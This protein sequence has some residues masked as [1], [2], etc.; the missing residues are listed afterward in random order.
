VYLFDTDVISHFRKIKPHPSLIQ[1]Y[2]GLPPDEVAISVMTIFEIQTG[3][4]ALRTRNPEKAQ[5]IEAW[6]DALVLSGGFK[7]LPI[8]T[9]IARTYGRMFATP[10]LKGFL[11]PD[12]MSPRPKSGADLVIAATAI[13]HGAIL[14]T[15]NASDFLRIHAEFPVPGLYEPFQG[16]WLVGQA[17]D[18][19]P[20]S[21]RDRA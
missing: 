12:P 3:V 8:D 9:R 15:G 21:G 14:V 2:E 17:V 13:A 1:W 19:A 4:S 20:S 11:L 6:L 16:R 18:L 5:S 7:I 10:S